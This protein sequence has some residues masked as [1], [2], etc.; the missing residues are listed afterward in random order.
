MTHNVIETKR[1]CPALYPGSTCVDR[2]DTVD[3]EQ[4]ACTI[5]GTDCSGKAT[6]CVDNAIGHCNDQG[7]ALFEKNCG[8]RYCMETDELEEAT[9]VCSEIGERCEV[10]GEQRCVRNGFSTCRGDVWFDFEI[11]DS[12]IGQNYCE[13]CIQWT[14]NEIQRAGCRV[15]DKRCEKNGLVCVDDFVGDCTH[16]EFPILVDECL[17]IEVCVESELDTGQAFCA[18]SDNP[19]TEDKSRYCVDEFP[20]R[21]ISCEETGYPLFAEYCDSGYCEQSNDD[22]YCVYR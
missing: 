16:A 3:G 21:V 8:D 10:N 4:P 19:C 15:D 12:C 6:I 20:D 22:A 18:V 13:D 17:Q 11:C 5:P 2:I 1:N 9:A 7:Q 14:E